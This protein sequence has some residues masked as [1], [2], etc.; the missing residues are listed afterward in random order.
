MKI[1]DNRQLKDLQADFKKEFP[2]LKIEFFREGHRHGMDSNENEKLDVNLRV[3]DIR[4]NKTSGEMPL[5]GN[6][7]TSIFEASFAENFG[8]NVQVYR[9]ERGKWL[10]TWVT[11]IW[12]LEEQNNRSK[13]MGDMDNLLSEEK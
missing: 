5:D 6:M 12:T 1:Q 2:Y 13:V 3:G 11:D 8:L 10:Q 9:K 4:T 7:T